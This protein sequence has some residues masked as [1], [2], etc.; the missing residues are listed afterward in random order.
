MISARK[1]LAGI[2]PYRPGKPI[3][4]VQRELGVKKII[5][6]ASNE[7][8]LGPS[9]LSTAAVKKYLGK[10]ELYPEGASPALRKA[11][12]K[13]L[14]VQ[15]ERVIAGNGSDEIIRL[16]C[17]AFLEPSD[18]VVVSEYAFIRFS[19]LA[20]LMGASVKKVP[21]KNWRHDLGAM[22]D[23]VDKNT[24]MLFVANPNNPTGTYNTGREIKAL[25]EKVPREVI[26]V[27]DEAYY[28]YA[29]ENPDYLAT[30]PE[31]LDKYPNLVVLRTFSK[32]YGL[33][34]YRV[35]Y[36]VAD[37]GIVALLDRIR[38]PFNVA[39]PSQIAAEA[40]LADNAFVRRSVGLMRT[41][42]PF[43]LKNLKKCGLTP[44][45]SAA[46]F[47]FAGVP[48]GGRELFN[49]LL[50][51]GVI[52]RPLDE[53]KLSGHVRITVGNRAQNLKLIS[54]LSGVL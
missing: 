32:V 1:C 21:M 16:L 49:R 25:L 43:V 29:V 5:K 15:Y 2:E 4:E 38:M 41:E 12:A 11:L 10:M 26:I 24:K 40:A 35:G 28:E 47:I 13:K 17:L 33:A 42:K 48:C 18:N 52:I 19:Q 50:S 45:P 23:A 6:L 53:Y 22:P 46:N 31:F 8:P 3:G 9:P 36:A 20:S 7:N 54:A 39:L 30:V 51:R 14:G 37:P 27:L 34:G 44:L